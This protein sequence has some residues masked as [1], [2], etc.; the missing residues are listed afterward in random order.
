MYDAFDVQDMRACNPKELD[1]PP[2]PYSY[3][4]KM[5]T[6]KYFPQYLGR[7]TQDIL[8]KI[9]SAYFTFEMFVKV[10]AQGFFIGEKTFLS[11]GPNWLDAVIVVG[12]FLDF[13]PAGSISLDISALRALRVLRP[14]RAVNKFPKLKNLV[15]LLG[16][17]VAKLVTVV[18]ICCF[19]FLVFGILGV[20]L[21]KGTLRGR[22]FD[23]ETGEV[24]ED[25]CYYDA[26][27]DTNWSNLDYYWVQKDM[28]VTG[29]EH[30]GGAFLCETGV[31]ICLQLGENPGR[32][33]VNFDSIGPAAMSIF[34]VMTLRAGQI[35][36][37]RSRTLSAT[38]TGCTLCCSS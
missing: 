33:T 4:N 7:D 18:G 21:Y 2:G 27:Y 12:G 25:I 31:S 11:D 13:V 10:V 28:V 32:D 36:A 1:M 29:G 6:G 37:I 26:L 14:L 8:G 23:I 15:V 24:G 17:C 9:F 19:L 5:G 38:G 35:C 20:Q 22:C 30:V 3:C 34:Q 16:Q